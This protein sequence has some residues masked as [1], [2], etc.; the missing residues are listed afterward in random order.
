MRRRGRL[1]I[2]LAGD[3]GP[4]WVIGGAPVYAAALP[5]AD[6]RSSPRSTRRSTATPYAPVSTT[7]D[8][9]AGRR[10]PGR[11]AGWSGTGLGYRFLRYE[12]LAR[13]DP[14]DRAAQADVGGRPACRRPGPQ[15]DVGEAADDEV[16]VQLVRRPSW[17]SRRG[18]PSRRPG[19]GQPAGRVLHHQAVRG[20]TPSRGAPSRKG[21]GSGFPRV[22]VVGGDHGLGHAQAGSLILAS[23]SARVHDVTTAARPAGSAASAVQRAR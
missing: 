11:R 1:G 16:G 9:A 15:I 12:R 6:P 13:A 7:H 22:H 21:S 23:A 4:L 8:V 18:S 10:R 14:L 20:R 5:L 19:R 17:W 2:E 3:A